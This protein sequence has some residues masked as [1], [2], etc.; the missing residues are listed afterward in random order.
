[1]YQVLCESAALTPSSKPLL[2]RQYPN[3][4]IDCSGEHFLLIGILNSF[5]ARVIIISKMITFLS[6]VSTCFSSKAFCFSNSLTFYS[7][8]NS[9][10]FRV[11]GIYKGVWLSQSKVPDFLGL[12]LIARILA[13]PLD[14][15]TSVISSAL[16]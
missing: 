15:L 1:M 2:H 6:D 7:S 10:Y 3:W 13:R 9:F 14:L 12:P 5:S 11:F 16:S 4:L 8:S